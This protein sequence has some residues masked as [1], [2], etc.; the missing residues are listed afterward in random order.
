MDG[1]GTNS[2]AIWYVWV[3][4]R[5]FG[6]VDIGQLRTLKEKGLLQ[7]DHWVLRAGSEDWMSA[8]NIANLFETIPR[9]TTVPS[10]KVERLLEPPSDDREL[11]MDEAVAPAQTKRLG[12]NYFARHWRGE[13]SLPVSYWVNGFLG[14]IIAAIVIA[15]LAQGLDFQDEYRPELALVLITAIWATVLFVTIWQTVGVWRAANNYSAKNIRSFWGGIAKFM[16]CVAV[17]RLGGQFA[18]TAIPQITEFVKIYRG[19]AEVGKYKFRILNGGQELEFT[20]G[21][22]FG[23]AKA[24]VGFADALS[25]LKTVRLTSNGG[26]LFEAQ[27]IAEQIKKRGLNTFVPSYCVSACTIVFLSGMERFI[28]PKSRLGFHQPDFPGIS[29]QARQEMIAIEQRRLISLGVSRAFAHKVNSTPPKNMWYPTVS[30][31]LADHIVTRVLET[32]DSPVAYAPFV[33]PEGAFSADF[34]GIPA[35]AKELGIPLKD[36]SKDSSYDS[37]MWTLES[38]E[39]Y[40]A[41]SMFTYSKPQPLDYDGAISGAANSVNATVVSQKRITL[42]GV[43]GRE[44]IFDAPKSIQMRMRLFIVKGRLYEIL[45]VTKSGGASTAALDAFLDSFRVTF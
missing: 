6:P 20:G 31:L 42:N 25:G 37:Y 17:L 22:T 10:L 14:N 39:A 44:A 8:A 23:A 4:D 34:G 7:P 15:F 38:G 30:E 45:I 13:L 32:G 11:P 1:A 21:I 18:T 29:D 41:V 5:Q 35:L 9:A 19:D 16:V 26:R 24:F 28:D 27:L 40:K 3:N 2:D 12:K 33:S 43:D 36:G